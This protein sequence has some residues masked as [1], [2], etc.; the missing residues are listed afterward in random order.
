M[1]AH[2]CFVCRAIFDCTIVGNITELACHHA[3]HTRCWHMWSRFH[4]ACPLCSSPLVELHV[5]PL[6][7]A[8][9]Q[10][11]RMRYYQQAE[12][13][14]AMLQEDVS[15]KDQRSRLMAAIATANCLLRTGR[16]LAATR[17]AETVME[18]AAALQSFQIANVLR[19]MGNAA[20]SME[21]SDHAVARRLWSEAHGLDPLCQVY[22]DALGATDLI[23]YFFGDEDAGDDGNDEHAEL[24]VRRYQEIERDGA[25]FL[26]I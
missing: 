4:W 26:F 17:I 3:S 21:T 19:L 5:D 13:L 15:P 9:H 11:I 7:A 1:D 14:L 12:E 6:F 23:V 18:Q 20:L 8:I 2:V 10:L 16:Y 22:V 25:I 24:L